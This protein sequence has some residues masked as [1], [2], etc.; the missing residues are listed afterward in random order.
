[1]GGPGVAFIFFKTVEFRHVLGI[2]DRLERAHVLSGGEDVPAAV[3]RVDL[4]DGPHDEFPL[5][6]LL[7]Q[8]DRFQRIDEIPPDHRLVRDRGD[9]AG[10]DQLGF[11]DLEPF[12]QKRLAVLPRRPVVEKEMQ[13][14]EIP[15]F[16]VDPVAREAAA[17]TVGALVHGAHGLG[18]EIPGDPAAVPVDHR[19]DGAARGDPD[20][21]FQF[22]GLPPKNKNAPIPKKRNERLCSFA[23]IIAHPPRGCQG[24]SV[25]KN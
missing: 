22:H 5:V 3:F 13:G 25:H 15:V 16:G 20:L 24:R 4:H 23:R 21:S 11:Y 10:R 9:L 2:A 6:D 18:R 14:V 17:E 1:M 12:L 8:K 7:G 19:G